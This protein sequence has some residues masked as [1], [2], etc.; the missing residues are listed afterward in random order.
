M[1]LEEVKLRREQLELS[2][3]IFRKKNLLFKLFSFS[4]INPHTLE[5]VV[6]KIGM[7]VE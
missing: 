6:E 2:S 1:N 5:D 7:V 3:T 4:G